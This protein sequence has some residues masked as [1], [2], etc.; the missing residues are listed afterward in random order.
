MK[1]RKATIEEAEDD[2]LSSLTR[3][4]IKL[5]EDMILIDNWNSDSEV[6]QKIRSAIRDAIETET[7]RA[8]SAVKET[9]KKK[10]RR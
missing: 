7:Y 10:L 1:S 6:F 9:R 3:I 8:H 4:I 2:F 5:F